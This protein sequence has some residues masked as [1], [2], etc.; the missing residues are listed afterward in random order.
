MECDLQDWAETA[1]RAIERLR[2]AALDPWILM[3]I[4]AI[5]VAFAVAWLAPYAA[6]PTCYA[7]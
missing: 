7:C 1:E 3:Q 6:I 5:V 2:E 4:A